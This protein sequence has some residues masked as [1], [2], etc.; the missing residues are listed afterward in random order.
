MTTPAASGAEDL[1]MARS[2]ETILMRFP[3]KRISAA[4][5][6]DGEP[7]LGCNT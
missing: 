2:L 1:P 6:V 7:F 3:G 5:L 4:F